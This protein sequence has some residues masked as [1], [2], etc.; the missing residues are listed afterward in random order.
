M[1]C[2]CVRVFGSEEESWEGGEGEGF[3]LCALDSGFIES[4][5]SI[6]SWRLHDI[7]DLV[8]RGMKHVE[9]NSK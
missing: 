1:T 4:I 3:V 8:L 9:L 5:L 6:P 2:G 7:D